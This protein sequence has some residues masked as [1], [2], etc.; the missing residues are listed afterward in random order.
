M[1]ENK[2]SSTLLRMELRGRW[3]LEVWQEDFAG[4]WRITGT[5]GREDSV[6]LFVDGPH[7][8]ETCMAALIL[9]ADEM[10]RRVPF[11]PREESYDGDLP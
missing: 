4:E 3:K 10:D 11:R 8:V 6:R 5:A 2:R 7:R 1:S 9:G